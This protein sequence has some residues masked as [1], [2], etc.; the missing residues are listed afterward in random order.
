[1]L[2]IETV[3]WMFLLLGVVTLGCAQ[4]QQAAQEAQNEVVVASVPITS[5]TPAKSVAETIPVPDEILGS[6]ASL[7]DPLAHDKAIQLALRNANLYTGEIDGKIG[8]LTKEAIKKFQISKSLKPD[9]VVG[10]KTWEELKA[11]LP[12]ESSR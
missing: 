10:P 4:R 2:K 6:S 12:E 9:G 1:M 8:P 3:V 7:L 11:Y 5:P